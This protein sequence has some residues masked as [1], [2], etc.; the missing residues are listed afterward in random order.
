MVKMLRP[1]KRQSILNCRSKRRLPLRK[2]SNEVWTDTIRH[3]RHP[4]FSETMENTGRSHPPMACKTCQNGIFFHSFP[5]SSVGMH[6]QSVVLRSNIHNE[7]NELNEFRIHNLRSGD[8]QTCRFANFLT[9]RF[10]FIQT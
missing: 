2:L 1:Y 5:R 8:F 3:C 9:C 7:L 4:G 6:T 10:I